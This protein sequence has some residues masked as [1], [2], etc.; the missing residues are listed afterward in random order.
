MGMLTEV[1]WADGET[2]DAVYNPWENLLY[3]TSW[4]RKRLSSA[5]STAQSRQ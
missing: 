4:M 3:K 2:K 1:M 5:I